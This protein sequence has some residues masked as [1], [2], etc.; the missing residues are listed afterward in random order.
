MEGQLYLTF[1]PCNPVSQG[2]KVSLIDYI[3]IM[4]CYTFIEENEIRICKSKGC[5]NWDQLREN[6]FP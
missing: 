2:L 4:Y 5:T 1:T 6:P 3:S